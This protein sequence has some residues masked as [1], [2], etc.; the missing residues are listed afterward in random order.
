MSQR[1]AVF[2]RQT[3]KP[4]K[5]IHRNGLSAEFEYSILTPLGQRAIPEFVV[6]SKYFTARA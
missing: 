3:L 6:N 5:R 2:Y 1:R 4:A